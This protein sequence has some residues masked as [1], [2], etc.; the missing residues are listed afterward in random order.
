MEKTKV[1]K[2]RG[3]PPKKTTNNKNS[4]K[5]RKAKYAKR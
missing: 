2:K 4:K 5:G 1:I 3:R